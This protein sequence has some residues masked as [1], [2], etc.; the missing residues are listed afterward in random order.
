MHLLLFVTL[1][2]SAACLAFDP[3][4][5]SL[6]DL[7]DHISRNLDCKWEGS[8]CLS[9]RTSFALSESDGAFTGLE[10]HFVNADYQHPEKS[11]EA[12]RVIAIKMV[13]ALL[14]EW[15]HAR[16][17]LENRMRLTQTE[18][19]FVDI[20]QVGNAWVVAEHMGVNVSENGATSISITTAPEAAQQVREQIKAFQERDRYS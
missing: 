5:L 10:M 17:W 1:C 19:G 18:Y 6:P 12:D 2:P 14:P 4:A 15:R 16:Q 11:V 7:K 3:L 13:M 20:S 8:T 9:S